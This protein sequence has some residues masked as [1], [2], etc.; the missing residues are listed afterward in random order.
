MTQLESILVEIGC[1]EAW[2]HTI[3][4]NWLK[5]KYHKHNNNKKKNTT[6]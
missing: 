1:E 3:F 2:E 4:I 6:N 5:N